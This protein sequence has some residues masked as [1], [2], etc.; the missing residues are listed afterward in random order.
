MQTVSEIWIGGVV[1]GWLTI[2]GEMGFYYNM[3][4][5]EVG[6]RGKIRTP[7]KDDEGR[8]DDGAPPRTSLLK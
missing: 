6:E 2:W 5:G 1:F 3:L 4:L 7:G 8:G